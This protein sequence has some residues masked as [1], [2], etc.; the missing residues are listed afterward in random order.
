MGFLKKLFSGFGGNS[1]PKDTGI[2]LYF[3]SKRAADAVT[4]IRIEPSYD[5]N[6][7]GDSL[8]WHKTIVDSRYFSRINAV[9]RFNSNHQVLSA[10]LDNGELISAEEYEAALAERNRP[11]EPEDELENLDDSGD[12]S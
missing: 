9:I 2:Y 4:K 5:L 11:E 7:D 8:S 3:R 6:R 10:D 12:E 1:Q